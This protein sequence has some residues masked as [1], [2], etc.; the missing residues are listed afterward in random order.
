MRSRAACPVR[1]LMQ[2]QDLADLL[3]D[4]VQRI[5][6]GHRLLEDDGDVVAAHVANFV[7][8]AGRSSSWPLK[9]T[10]PDGWL[11]GGIGQELQHR[12]RGHRLA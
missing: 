6:R 1:P 11:R 12:E 5:E 4:G 2:Q 7:L 3:L 9:R 8:R 10:E